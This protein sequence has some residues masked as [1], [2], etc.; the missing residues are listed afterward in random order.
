MVVRFLNGLLGSLTSRTMLILR[1]P[2]VTAYL[3][4]ELRM[5]FRIRTEFQDRCFASLLMRS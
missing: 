5:I 1:I 3:Y 4:T 2:L